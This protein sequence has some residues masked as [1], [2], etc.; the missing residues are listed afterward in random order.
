MGNKCAKCGILTKLAV[1][2]GDFCLACTMG[3]HNDAPDAGIEGLRQLIECN[4]KVGERECGE[5]LSC[6][7]GKTKGVKATLSSETEKVESLKKALA[8]Y[9][10]P[11]VYIENKGPGFKGPQKVVSDC[12]KK[13]RLALGLQL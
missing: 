5:C 6:E 8:F 4:P 10:D 13:A 11:K 1:K 9:A 12:G 2:E 3:W 7:R